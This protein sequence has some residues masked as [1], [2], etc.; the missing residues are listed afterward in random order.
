MVTSGVLAAVLVLTAADGCQEG[1]AF[2][3][4]ILEWP[5]RSVPG[6]LSDIAREEVDAIWGRLGVKVRWPPREAPGWPPAVHVIVTDEG[7]RTSMGGGLSKLGWIEFWGN[8]PGNVLQVS[9]AA[10]LMAV[11]E[12]RTVGRLSSGQPFG[13][14]QFAAA[15]M[16][17]RAIAHE[18]GH[19]LLRS[20]HHAASGLMRPVFPAVEGTIPLLDRYR[21]DRR[22]M[23][24]LRTRSGDLNAPSC[25]AGRTQARP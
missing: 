1:R 7:A 8:T 18:L 14:L 10:A 4:V 25:A 11:H 21:L 6:P 22:A 16:I 24:I 5:A 15:R 3:R 19:Y 23:E 20:R 13:A 2:V 9:A 17:G 12:G